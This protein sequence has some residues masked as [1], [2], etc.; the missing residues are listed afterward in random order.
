MLNLTH[1]P[2]LL[3]LPQPAPAAGARAPPPQPQPD[4]SEYRESDAEPRP[5]FRGVNESFLSRQRYL[6]AVQDDIDLMLELTT[7]QG[8]RHIPYTN[9]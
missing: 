3:A 2:W 7:P 4:V 6:R 9:S 8:L 1:E 5:P